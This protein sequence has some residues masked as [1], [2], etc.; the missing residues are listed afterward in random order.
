MTNDGKTNRLNN[1][2][3]ITARGRYAGQFTNGAGLSVM[4]NA[5]VH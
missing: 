1:E 4:T 3:L 5:P 2:L